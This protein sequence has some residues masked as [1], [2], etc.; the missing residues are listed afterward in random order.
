MV[1]LVDEA[2]CELLAWDSAFWGFPVARVRGDSLTPEQVAAIDQWCKANA[3]ACLYFLATFDDPVTVHCAEMSGFELVDVRLTAVL[4]AKQFALHV[5]PTAPPELTIRPATEADLPALQRLASTN[6]PT[7]R[8]Y[9]DRHFP[10]DTCAALYA[11]WITESVRAQRDLVLVAEV[12]GALAGYATFQLPAA[13]ATARILLINT[14]PNARHRGAARELLREGF[15]RL[16]PHDVQNLIGITQVR[17]IAVQAFNARVGFVPQ[18]C[19]L[20]Y[21]KWYRDPGSPVS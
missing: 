12:A 18:S 13:E 2:P 14:A 8:F 7:T 16:A 3:I 6:Y 11:H 15:R 5:P 20:W 1:S 17:N 4:T 10:R 21:H 19:Q 9:F